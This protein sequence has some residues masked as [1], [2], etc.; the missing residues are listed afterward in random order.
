MTT[1]IMIPIRATDREHLRELIF[2]HLRDYG[3][4]CS[5]NHIDVS[6]IN[7]FDR[8]FQHLDFNGDISEWD[9]SQAISMDAMFEHSTFDGDI[10]N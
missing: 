1:D 4:E 9:V 7:D 2:E 10:S 5:L 8:L 3:F 6:R